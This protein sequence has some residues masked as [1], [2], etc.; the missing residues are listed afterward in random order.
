MANSLTDSTSARSSAAQPAKV[1][2]FA[3]GNKTD[4]RK[5]AKGHFSNGP[6]A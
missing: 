3:G 2:S 4:V 1:T 6:A 5:K